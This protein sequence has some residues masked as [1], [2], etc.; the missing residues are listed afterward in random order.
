VSGG[1]DRAGADRGGAPQDAPA[2]EGQRDTRDRKG[3]KSE[4]AE[5]ERGGRKGRAS[6]PS[7]DD[8]LFGTRSDE[9]PA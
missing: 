6:I 9:D 4:P 5:N 7:W 8:I 2:R 1:P 3:D